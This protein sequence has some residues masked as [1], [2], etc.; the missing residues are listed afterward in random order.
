MAGVT[1]GGLVIPLPARSAITTRPR[2]V[3]PRFASE[4]ISLSP[5]ASTLEALCTLVGDC[6]SEGW[7]GYGAAAVKPGAI[8]EAVRF[9]RRLPG[10]VEP[11]EVGPEPDGCVALEWSHDGVPQFSISFAGT[12]MLDY[13]GV[14]SDGCSQRGVERF[15]EFVPPSLSVVLETRFIH[16]GANRL[17]RTGG[18]V[19][20]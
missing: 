15:V 6:S 7:D 2:G 8:E 13:A 16:T 9:L 3:W 5:F 14:F 4:P 12:S 1:G 11:P 10:Y 20:S 18:S 17:R 19:R